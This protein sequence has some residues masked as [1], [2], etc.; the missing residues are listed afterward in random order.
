MLRPAAPAVLVAVLLAGCG[1]GHGAIDPPA[2]EPYEVTAHF[3]SAADDVSGWNVWVRVTPTRA[4]METFA[5]ELVGGARD[6]RR[7]VVFYSK[8]ERS[9]ALVPTTRG[10]PVIPTDHEA[11]LATFDYVGADARVALNIP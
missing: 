7:Y 5:D 1:I 11:W 9:F 10:A 8:P 2:A 3:E 4:G 6:G